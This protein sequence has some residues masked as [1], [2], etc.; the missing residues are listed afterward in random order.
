MSVK[1]DGNTFFDILSN[2]IPVNMNLD[3]EFKRFELV[4][5]AGGQDIYYYINVNKPSIGIIQK[6]PEYSNI[7]NAL[8]VFS[9]RNQN[10][11]TCRISPLCVNEIQINPKHLNLNFN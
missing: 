2:N 9:S 3:R 5:S 1:L 6:K 11:I 8:G 10:I 4:F 7:E